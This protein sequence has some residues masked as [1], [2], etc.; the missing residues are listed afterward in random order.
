MNKIATESYCDRIQETQMAETPFSLDWKVGE[1][2]QIFAIDTVVIKHTSQGQPI[3]IRRSD[4][5][6]FYEY[7]E[8]V[9]L[10]NRADFVSSNETELSDYVHSQ[11]P[12]AELPTGYTGQ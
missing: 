11:M 12:T 2:N 9:L 1:L 10:L 6:A 4:L 3:R 8:T 7:A 5:P